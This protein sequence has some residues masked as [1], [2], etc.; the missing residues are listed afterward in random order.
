ML[1][2]KA[3]PPQFPVDTVAA[4]IVNM[5]APNNAGTFS[6]FSFYIP[7]ASF[8]S[9]SV[10]LGKVWLNWVSFGTFPPVVKPLASFDL[11]QRVLII[12]AKNDELIKSATIICDAYSMPFDMYFAGQGD[13]SLEKTPDAFGKYHMVVFVS[14]MK[15][16]YNFN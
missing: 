4:A 13:F 6:Q 1:R 12:A 7:F 8:S 5:T 10:N 16:E 2:F 3:F 14:E 9:T 11:D 15:C